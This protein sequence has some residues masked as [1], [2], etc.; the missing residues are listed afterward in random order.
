[1]K[2]VL[3]RLI[4]DAPKSAYKTL[5]QSEKDLSTAYKNNVKNKI[6]KVFFGKDKFK[7]NSSD[8]DKIGKNVIEVYLNYYEDENLRKKASKVIE[9]FKKIYGEEPKST[10]VIKSF[11]K[12]MKIAWARCDMLAC[13]L[14]DQSKINSFLKE[15]DDKI[16]KEYDKFEKSLIGLEGADVD[17]ELAEKIKIYKN[18]KSKIQEARKEILNDQ[19][20]MILEVSDLLSQL[21]IVRSDLKNSYIT[22]ERAYDKII[23]LLRKLSEIKKINRELSV[24]NLTNITNEIVESANKRKKFE[25]EF[26]EFFVFDSNMGIESKNVKESVEFLK[27]KSSFVITGP[28]K[29]RDILKKGEISPQFDHTKGDKMAVF[30]G[31]YYILLNSLGKNYEKYKFG[32]YNCLNQK[33]SSQPD[34]EKEAME[35]LKNLWRNR[36]EYKLNA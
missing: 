30:V 24:E 11:G 2:N 15:I 9:K 21:N 19:K 32:N 17:R 27:K 8:G 34:A 28:T 13:E 36:G 16:K 26:L 4:L 1:M 5:E 18:E 22:W 12:L 20:K 23:N 10:S 33:A 29:V 14:L 35:T 25:E 3:S 6:K 31:P 7:D